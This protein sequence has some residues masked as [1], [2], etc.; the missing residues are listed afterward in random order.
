M[1]EYFTAGVARRCVPLRTEFLFFYT[2]SYILILLRPGHC[3]CQYF[4]HQ[5]CSHSQRIC[6]VPFT[7]LARLHRL[8]PCSLYKLMC[9]E[10]FYTRFFYYIPFLLEYLIF[11]L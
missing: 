3:T 7:V 10:K 8:L 6:P 11:F 2:S 5:K 1:N 4:L 9:W